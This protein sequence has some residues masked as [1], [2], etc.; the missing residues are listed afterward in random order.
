[1][2]KCPYCG[3]ENADDAPVCVHCWAKMEHEEKHEEKTVKER[4]DKKK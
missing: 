1:M 3:R 4:A 2:E